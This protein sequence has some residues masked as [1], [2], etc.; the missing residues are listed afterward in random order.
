MMVCLLTRLALV[1]YYSLTS[2]L[3][4]LPRYQVCQVVRLTK[5]EVFLSWSVGVL[6]IR[7]F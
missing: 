5:H 4:T 7:Y 3:V 2:H 6:L 1:A